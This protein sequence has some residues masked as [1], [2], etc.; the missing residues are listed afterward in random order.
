MDV[1]TIST[2]FY[3]PL[4]QDYIS[5]PESLNPYLLDYQGCDWLDLH[6]KIA[7]YTEI[8]NPVKKHLIEQNSDLTTEAAR[9]NIERLQNSNCLMVV[10]GQQLGLL[11]SPLYTI[12][13]AVTTIK[14]S[15]K[16]ND[17]FPDIPFVPVFW[18]ES[19]DHDFAEVNH[20]G[21]WDLELMPRQLVYNGH[22]LGKSPL[23]YY[24][25]DT[26]ISILLDEIKSGLQPT[27]FSAQLMLLLQD[28]YRVGQNWVEAARNFL[29]YLLSGQ[30]LL[31]FQPGTTAIKEIS[32]PFFE[33]LLQKSADVNKIF[34]DTSH[35]LE[36]RGYKNQVPVIAGKTFIHFET[37]TRQRDQL[38]SRSGQ[39]FLKETARKMSAAEVHK[40]ITRFPLKVSSSVISRP[41]LQSWLLPAA[42][43]VA[44]PAEVA[45]WAQL[46][47]IFDCLG[48]IRPVVY[49]R[50]TATLLEPKIARFMQKHHPDI[51]N[52]ILSKTNFIH[53]YFSRRSL[54]HGGNPVQELG[55]SFKEK[56]VKIREYLHHLDPTLVTVGS[57]VL[58]RIKNQIDFLQERIIKSGEQKENLLTSHLAQIHQAILPDQQPQ[59]RYISII[60]FLN[61]F[62]PAVMEKIYSDLRIDSFRHQLLYL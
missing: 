45:Y 20:I 62:G 11:A 44:G 31:F 52:I 29:K 40:F 61:K 8:H 7:V 36:A 56:E 30:G 22:H 41:L 60:Y 15:Q 55:N 48:L 34:A 12:Y 21:I 4:Y 3:N 6:K 9:R 38:Y 58:E 49:P 25:I 50:I 18:M 2:S 43:Y 54:N 32:V 5:R 14:L 59:E 51:E 39:Y 1:N 26:A 57:K 23:R 46:G 35:D 24:R 13:K 17:S 19:E 42:V 47:S 27:E 33:R 53:D 10:T 16:L 37:D 28:F